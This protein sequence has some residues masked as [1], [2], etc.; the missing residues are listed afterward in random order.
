MFDIFKPFRT[1]SEYPSEAW[2]K[3]DYAPQHSPDLFKLERK[4]KHLLFEHGDLMSG[5]PKHRHF[6]EGQALTSAFTEENFSVIRQKNGAN[7]FPITLKDT[8]TRQPRAQVKG[9]LFL[10]T[11]D[12]ILDI[13]NYRQ[14]TVCFIRK[15][16][17]IILPSVDKHGNHELIRAYMYVSNKP[18]WKEQLEWDYAMFKGHPESNFAPVTMYKDGRYNPLQYYYFTSAEL[19]TMQGRHSYIHIHKGLRDSVKAAA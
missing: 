12:T 8:P 10:V 4:G 1:T 5:M 9:Q 14:N 7:N 11:G 15:E 13:D 3:E 16:A 2:L 17:K 18:Y 6:I 19:R